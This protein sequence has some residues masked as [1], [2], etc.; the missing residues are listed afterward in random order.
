MEETPFQIGV[1]SAR[2]LL[3]P[4]LILL[5][6]G[7]VLVISYYNVPAV[8]E[9]LG[10][11]A[12]WRREYGVGFVLGS[13][14][15]LAGFTPWL[16]RMFVPSL[17]PAKPVAELLFS[18]LWWGFILLVVD[19]FYRCLGAAFDHR[20][21]PF[22]AVVAAKVCCDMF[23][24]TTFFAAPANALSHL[25]KD[26]GFSFVA[27][28]RSLGPGWYRRLVLP[29]LIPNYMVWFPG[30]ALVYSMPANLQLPMANLIG[31]FWA[32][33]CIQIAARSKGRVSVEPELAT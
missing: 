13:S 4:A 19:V 24:F 21:W 17:R 3:A 32:L 29:N 8:A 26:T 23:G 12:D 7:L 25:W 20:G 27:M 22:P 1:R 30:V 31:C 5:T 28:R 15:L 33:M 10:H 14:V 2:A 11:V 16:F 18:I 9:A 6:A